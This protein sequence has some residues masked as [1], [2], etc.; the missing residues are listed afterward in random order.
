M[1]IADLYNGAFFFAC[2]LCEYSKVTGTQRI[3]TITLRNII[4]RK[5]NKIMTDVNKM[6]S[7]DYVSITSSL[8]KNESYFNIVIQQK[9]SSKT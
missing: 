5:V 6:H 2:R 9:K 4:F 8:Q 1:H 3:N 7:A